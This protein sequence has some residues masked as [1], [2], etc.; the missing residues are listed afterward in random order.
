MSARISCDLYY[1]HY[2]TSVTKYLKL[3]RPDLKC[4]QSCWKT[5][6]PDTPAWTSYSRRTAELITYLVRCKE[7]HQLV[8]NIFRGLIIDQY[9]IT[10]EDWIHASMEFFFL[11]SAGKAFIL[12]ELLYFMPIKKTIAEREDSLTVYSSCSL[13]AKKLTLWKEYRAVHHAEYSWL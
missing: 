7:P 9:F 12:Q 4:S 13:R 6:G 1:F 3:S 8:T 11:C 10:A 2:F 5:S